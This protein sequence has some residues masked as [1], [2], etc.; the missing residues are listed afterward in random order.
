M[1]A[2]SHARPPAGLPLIPLDEP[3]ASVDH[4]LEH[5]VRADDLAE[6][7]FTSGTTARPKGVMLTH[8]NITWN[9]VNLLSVADFRGD[10]VTVAVAPFFRT[11]G[12]GVNVL[13]VLFKGGAVVVPTF[14]PAFLLRNPGPA[15][16][17]QAYDDLK[18]IRREYDRVRAPAG[19]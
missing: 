1:L 2:P 8:G 6:I 13:P 4:P 16:R 10:D 19:A 9:I 15:F 5:A 18:L 17:R 14:H 7:V 3:Q 11:G 12:T